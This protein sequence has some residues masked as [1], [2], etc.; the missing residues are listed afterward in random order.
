MRPKWVAEIYASQGKGSRNSLHIDRLAHDFEMEKEEDYK[1]A[2]EYWKSLHPDNCWGGDFKGKTAGDI[3]HFS[4][5]Y[6]GRK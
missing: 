1:N 4:M 2:A 5:S 3:Y 6:G